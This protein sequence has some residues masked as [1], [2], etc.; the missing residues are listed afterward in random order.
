[1]SGINEKKF[2]EWS[3]KLTR[4][5]ENTCNGF[6]QELIAMQRDF[7]M[8]WNAVNVIIRV[9]MK[10]AGITEEDFKEAAKELLEESM[11]RQRQIEFAAKS[12]MKTEAKDHP[13]PAWTT[14]ALTSKMAEIYQ[15]RQKALRE[16]AKEAETLEEEKPS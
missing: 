13:Y 7:Q 14:E 16:L 5:I 4:H 8:R 11:A 15:E 2:H 12:G 6:L 9:M 3:D 10:K 1:M